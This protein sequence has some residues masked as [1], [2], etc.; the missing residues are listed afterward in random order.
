MAKPKGKKR[1]IAN[2]LPGTF[3][4]RELFESKAFLAL[5]GIAPQLLVLILGKRKF[6]NVGGKKT[7]INGDNI[8]FTYIEAKKKYGISQPRLTRC[9]D[10]LLAK[11]FLKIIHQ[12]GAYKQDK[13]IY[14]L[15]DAWMYWSKGAVH[16]RRLK[17]PCQKGFRKPKKEG[18]KAA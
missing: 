16:E 9:I 17:D 5:G 3:I 10:E 7:L 13:T 1:W 15:S 14:G 11:G 18:Q 8:T 4:Y 12:G 2:D 6:V